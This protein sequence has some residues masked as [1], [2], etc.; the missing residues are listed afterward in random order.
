MKRHILTIFILILLLVFAGKQY[1]EYF[2]ATEFNIKFMSKYETYNYLLTDSDQFIKNTPDNHMN[3][4]GYNDTEKYK[5]DVARYAVSFNEYEKKQIT[6]LAMAVDQFLVEEFGI[7]YNKAKS[8]QWVFALTDGEAYD[9]GRP[10]VRNGIIFLSTK[11]IEQE[12]DDQCQ[13][14]F[15][16]LYLRQNILFGRQIKTSLMPWDASDRYWKFAEKLPSCAFYSRINYFNQ[17][18]DAAFENEYMI[19]LDAKMKRIRGDKANLLAKRDEIDYK[20]NP[21]EYKVLFWG[22]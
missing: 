6:I 19:D 2:I 7:E 11:T 17:Y 16:L 5:K 4:Y 14:G 10:H 1:K 9:D 12:I 15:T 22:R 20:M 13:F 8:I 18:Y 3:L 21:E